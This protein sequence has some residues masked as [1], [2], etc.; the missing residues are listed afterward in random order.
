MGPV[1]HGVIS[2]G[3]GGAVWGATGSAG[4]G[5]VALGVGTLVDLDHLYDYYQWYIR[6]RT[7]KLHIFLHAWEYSIVGLLVTGLAYYHPLLLGTVLAH[8]GHVVTDHF[9]NRLAPFGY[10][11]TYRTIVGFEA[12]VI[13]PDQDVEHS[14]HAWPHLLPFGWLIEP[15]FNRRIEPWIQGRLKRAANQE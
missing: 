10:S 7:K 9:H 1:G 6:R 4:A 8:L 12:S 15:W 14:Y 13:A 2:A 11:I 5:A 3:I